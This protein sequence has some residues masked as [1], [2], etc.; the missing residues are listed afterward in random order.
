MENIRALGPK[1]DS[2]NSD[3]SRISDDHLEISQIIHQTFISVD[4]EGTEAAAVT[5]AV[6]IVGCC[7]PIEEEIVDFKCDRPFLF[8]IHGNSDNG[9]LFLGKYVKP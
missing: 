4:E 3:F 8:V 5:A 7:M 9:I 6:M 1:L 2:T